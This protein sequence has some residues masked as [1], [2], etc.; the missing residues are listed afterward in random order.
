[1]VH[2]SCCAFCCGAGCALAGRSRF[3]VHSSCCAV[4]CGAGCWLAG[5]SHDASAMRCRC[6]APDASRVARR[7]RCVA[8][9]MLHGNSQVGGS[10]RRESSPMKM[11][12]LQT[13]I[14]NNTHH[15]MTFCSCPFFMGGLVWLF[16][17]FTTGVAPPVAHRAPPGSIGVALLLRRPCGIATLLVEGANWRERPPMKMGKH[18]TVTYNNTHYPMTFLCFPIFIGGVVA[19]VA[20]STAGVAPLVVR[21]GLS[22]TK[23][24]L[25]ASP[26]LH[27]RWRVCC[28]RVEV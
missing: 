20:P 19:P 1:M 21:G 16:A 18:K 22:L 4:C 6:C 3:M 15:P 26:R 10:F 12:Q 9:G 2:S 8:A 7:Q 17:P 23:K 24:W 13:V 25:A 14:Y 5:R 28:W 27:C 11:G